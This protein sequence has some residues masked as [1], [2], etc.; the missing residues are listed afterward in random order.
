MTK[1]CGCWRL[2]MPYL[3]SAISQS[4]PELR[5]LYTA[6]AMFVANAHPFRHRR[7]VLRIFPDR[8]K[9]AMNIWVQGLQPSVHEFR[10]SGQIRDIADR[11]ARI[12]KRRAVPPVDTSSTPKPARP[13]AKP[14]RLVLS[15]TE[16][17]ARAGRRRSA[18][19][20]RFSPERPQVSRGRFRVV[21]CGAFRLDFSGGQRQ[22]IA[23]NRPEHGRESPAAAGRQDSQGAVPPPVRAAARKLAVVGTALGSRAFWATAHRHAHSSIGGLDRLPDRPM[24][25]SP[26][27]CSRQEAATTSGGAPLLDTAWSQSAARLRHRARNSICSAGSVGHV[28]SSAGEASWASRFRTTNAP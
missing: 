3:S 19:I 26:S 8:Q 5:N 22:R 7:L 25:F 20:A 13:R 27:A 17:N 23:I 4:M 18:G 24:T 28:S 2:A 21:G 14:A 15:E 11:Q 6:Q 16:S 10:E 1:R 12:G 9:P